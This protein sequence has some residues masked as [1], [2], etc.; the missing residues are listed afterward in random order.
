MADRGRALL[1]VRLAPMQ[2]AND[3]QRAV[4]VKAKEYTPVTHAKPPVGGE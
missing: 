2:D 1:P 3:T 4:T